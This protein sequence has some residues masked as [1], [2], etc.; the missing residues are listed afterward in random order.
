VDGKGEAGGTFDRAVGK[1][2][3]IPA[4]AVAAEME[5]GFRDFD[6]SGEVVD[7]PVGVADSDG[8]GEGV[9]GGSGNGSTGWWGWFVVSHPFRIRRGG[10]RKGWGNGSGGGNLL[11]GEP[12]TFGGEVEGDGIAGEGCESVGLGESGG[13]GEFASAREGEKRRAK[14]RGVSPPEGK[15]TVPARTGVDPGG[16][17]TGESV[18]FGD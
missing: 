18:I 17:R 2:D 4:L 5:S 3:R 1:D 6:W 10:M 15:A 12:W 13:V 14:V 9:G 7:F 16:D 11:G 8:A